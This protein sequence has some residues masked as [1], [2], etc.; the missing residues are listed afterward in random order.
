MTLRRFQARGLAPTTSP[1]G[2]WPELRRCLA[3]QRSHCGARPRQASPPPGRRCRQSRAPADKGGDR[4]LVGGIEDGGR[5]AAGLE[6][7]AAESPALGTASGRAPRR[8]SEATLAR[9]SLAPDRRFASARPGNGRSG[10]ACPASRAAPPTSRRGTPPCRGRS[11]ADA[12]ARRA[13]PAPWRTGD[14]PRSTPGPCSSW[15]RN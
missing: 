4:D 12:P 1:Y 5:R 3:A 8:S 10:C 7:P 13:L 9:S 15:L 11:T 6:R 2:Q 14:G